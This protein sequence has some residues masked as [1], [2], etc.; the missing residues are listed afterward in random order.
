MSAE[1][2]IDLIERRQ[3][4][5]A[6]LV[7]KLRAKVADSDQPLSAASL[8]DILV[9]KNYLSSEQASDLLN[10]S[11]AFKPETSDADDEALPGDS[12]IFG[13]LFTGKGTA[14]ASANAADNEEVF[15]LTP[16]DEDL[17]LLGEMPAPDAGQLPA[18]RHSVSERF[19]VERSLA[20]KQPV[21][22]TDTL[23]SDAAPA[24]P[25]AAP[26]AAKSLRK[27]PGLKKKTKN[28][29]PWDSPLFL[30][31]GGVLVLLVICGGTVA[32]ILSRRGG[33]E[34]LAEAR[35]YRDV[36]AFAQA[37]GSYQQF[38]A[39]YPSDAS[40]SDARVEL[41]MTRL[42]QAIESDGSFQPALEIAQTELQALESDKNFDQQKLAEAKPELAELL[43][44]IASGLADEADASDDPTIAERL[45]KSAG[46]ALDL[47]RNVK[48]VSKELRDDDALADVE[49][50]LARVARRGQTRGDL[51]KALATIQAAVA[52]GD[53][54]AAYAAHRQ[55]V[56]Q[57]PELAVNESLRAIIV[58]ATTVEQAGIKY[59]ADQ[60]AAE[61]T[62]RP[63]PW[64]VALAT[65]NR[66]V[67]AEAPAHGTFC[68]RID[69]ALAAFDVA[70]GKMLWQR[71]VGFATGL[72]PTLVGDHVL[73]FDSKHQE[74][75]C[76]EAR[77]GKL[78]WCQEFGEPI[79][80]PL[81]V[82][83]RAY[84]AAESGRLYLVDLHSGMRMGYLPFAQPLRATPIVDRTGQRL[85]L[86]GDHSS[87][88]T[89][90]RD[91]LKCLGVYYLGHSSGSI[92]VPPT[93]V[94]DRLAVLENDGVSSC[95]LRI[96]S[97]DDQRA[98]AKVETD[99][100]L[101]GL[102]ASPPLVTSR[103]LI[104]LTDR[105]ELDAFDV[106][107][108]AGEK[109]LT[110]VATREPT[111]HEPLVR[112]A[113][114]T[115]GAIWIGDTQLTKYAVLP[116][117][118]RMPVQSIE[119]SFVRST[120]DQPLAL[121]GSVL[122]HVRRLDGRAG[123]V[124]TAINADS[125]G[126]FWSNEL[127]VPPA[128]TPIVDDADQTLA[129]VDVNGL[130]YRFDEATLRARVQD[131][132]LSPGSTMSN[133]TKLTVGVD[134]GAGRGA[135]AAPTEGNQLMLYDPAVAR[136]PIRWANLPSTIACAMSPLGSGV[137]VP[138]EV[139]QVFYLNPADG[140]PLAAP[141]QP[142]LEPRT[143]TLYQ[144]AAQAD[145]AGRQ[146]VI[147]DGHDKIYFV[148]LI[149]QP[150]P[151]FETLA[152][153]NVGAFAI[154]SPIRVMH[155]TAFA[156][157][158]GGQLNRFALPSLDNVG[159]TNLPGEVIWGPY[160]AGNL[161]VVATSNDQLVAVNPDGSIAWAESVKEGDLAGPPLAID[162][163]VLL[164]Y[165]RGIFERRRLANGKT[166]GRLDVEHPLAAGPVRFLDHIVLTT[167]DGTLLVVEQP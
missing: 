134:L 90:S 138:L 21:F 18:E 155:S 148:E 151:H 156:V 130:V 66:Q 153:Q 99:R 24:R 108:A 36:G 75:L 41:A 76:L 89:L 107:S 125:G 9:R 106:G 44:R 49:Q 69:G 100:R 50:D 61:T 35:K 167:H 5:P 154:V 62:E 8:A 160:R 146:F 25:S 48:Y 57:H 42:R 29:N 30:M 80:A 152:Q 102:A 113:L 135:F 31:G 72:P 15:T 3:M 37:I 40:W 117:G 82:E 59:V 4:L 65:G 145:E 67:K 165:R 51:K 10:D 1:R 122:V 20:A 19:E 121:F 105:G 104:V 161:F 131:Q 47:C 22:P 79:A 54:R 95:R 84:V 112:H 143:K 70:T 53:T 136:T 85:Y 163:N 74:L 88:Y 6:Q 86:T 83:D 110:Q 98:V 52:A 158:D 17:P 115:Q 71:Y 34:K 103:R 63:T 81:V 27:A 157:C 127:A 132:P 55:L 128:A 87:I 68:A 93:Q 7:E 141:F 92:R 139:G 91:D 144:P 11:A 12:S 164:T 116:T 119:D 64:L 166:V 162:Q 142:R 114:L 124:V 43:P 33:D 38:V 97:L 111:S 28:K 16:T 2:L 96:L 58:K 137:L 147:T 32:L 133:R 78:V 150:R 159:Q 39:E 23:K 123:V 129:L 46:E 13:P 109:A 101:K 26:S 149:D 73:V 60:H 45:S 140:Q 120:F 14:S 126:V 118:N 56:E 94:L 77:T